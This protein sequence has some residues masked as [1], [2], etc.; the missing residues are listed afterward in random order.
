MLFGDAVLLVLNEK[1]EEDWVCLGEDA[2][3]EEALLGL[4]ELLERSFKSMPVVLSWSLGLFRSTGLP[5]GLMTCANTTCVLLTLPP[6]WFT[7]G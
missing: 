5:S 3:E 4:L 1:R 2:G 6:R 7:Q